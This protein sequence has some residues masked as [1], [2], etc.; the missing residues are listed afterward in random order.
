MHLSGYKSIIVYIA[1]INLRMY[2]LGIDRFHFRII[3]KSKYK[4]NALH[5]G[6]NRKYDKLV[7]W[8]IIIV[9]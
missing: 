1:N 9:S 8:N 4:F 7:Y 6:Y 5:N 2:I 3:L